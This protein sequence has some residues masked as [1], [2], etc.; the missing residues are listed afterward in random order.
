MLVTCVDQTGP[1]DLQLLVCFVL[2]AAQA[3][4]KARRTELFPRYPTVPY[5]WFIL[6]DVTQPKY[7]GGKYIPGFRTKLGLLPPGDQATLMSRLAPRWPD[8]HF[9][10]VCSFA[11]TQ[12]HIASATRSRVSAASTTYS[13][14]T[15]RINDV[16]L[17]DFKDQR[18]IP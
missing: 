6:V 8:N 17:D 5:S 2:L 3:T 18:R 12:D 4:L 16:F 10:L 1:E 7:I 11:A 15:L 13:L 9:P 14:R